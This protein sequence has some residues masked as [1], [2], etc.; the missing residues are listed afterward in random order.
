MSDAISEFRAP[1]DA[2]GDSL[3]A[4]AITKAASLKL[5]VA[6]SKLKKLNRLMR[7][8]AQAI[9]AQDFREAATLALQALD[10]DQE[11]PLANHVA[12][13]AVDRMG[14]VELALKL[15]LR[16]IEFD[17]DNPEIYEN[18]GLM[19]WRME[20]LEQA[21]RFFR[22]QQQID[23][24][25]INAQNNL[26]CVLRDQSRFGEA[27]EILRSAIYANPEAAILWTAMG[28]TMMEQSQTKEA[29]QFHNEAARL[30]PNSARIQ[31]NLGYTY[32]VAGEPQ[33]AL[34]C[35]NKAQDL[36][37]LPKF[38]QTV[39]EYA[40][41]LAL[42]SLGRLKEGWQ[43]YKAMHSPY[44][45][46]GTRY[47]IDLPE[48]KEG[49]PLEGKKLLLMGE[50]GLGDEILF[51]SMA[52][53]IK[54]KLVG[55]DGKLGISCEH[56][57]VNLFARSFPDME[58]M[59]HATKG[60]GGGTLRAP[61]PQSGKLDYDCWMRMAT[62]LRMIRNDV[63]D[64][65]SPTEGFLKPDP[66]R[67][68]HWR[69][70]LDDMGPGLKCGLLWKS[71]IMTANRLKNYATF[72]LW[73]PVLTTPGVTW[74]NLQYG[75]TD[76]EITFAMEKFGV[77]F[78]TLPGLD[79]MNDLDDLAAVGQEIDISMGPSNATLNITGG[80]GGEIWLV[81]PNSAWT[82]LG[83]DDY[84]W[85]PNT[86]VFTSPGMDNWDIAINKLADALGERAKAHAAA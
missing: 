23:P 32:V 28:A 15:Y 65:D 78:K 48:W 34:D 50:Q 57:L 4:T 2:A 26:G 25:S 85:Y 1:A 60:H 7:K 64:F 62:P 30:D 9:N 17:P 18:L 10:I 84:L 21:E 79:L 71:K 19:T 12:A 86:R 45:V 72:D 42:L 27:I 83:Q 39:S 67:V 11:H 6:A 5:N 73:K 14:N 40:R 80:A 54:D 37:G 29:L 41:G 8:A 47:L 16:A 81:A 51:L 13:I 33:Q 75:E 55:P 74:V 36:G 53:D 68:A 38:E 70:V 44:Y 66:E 20:K 77:E 22:L 56:R 31:H 46:R 82:L 76:E 3:K 24:G 69:A 49:E 35:F 43:A 63:S 59:P 52:N 61:K 58:V